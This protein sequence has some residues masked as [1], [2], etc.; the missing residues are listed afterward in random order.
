MKTPTCS[1][2]LNK[3]IEKQLQP[4]ET[5]NAVTSRT[6]DKVCSSFKR[7]MPSLKEIIKVRC[8][9]ESPSMCMLPSLNKV[10]CSIVSIDYYTITWLLCAFSLVVDRDLLKDTQRW[11]Q[12]HISRLVFLFSCPP[13]S[14]YK[15][16]EFLL[17]KTNTSQFSLCV[18]CNRSHRTSQRVN[19]CSL[20]A[21]TSFVIYYIT[22]T[23]KN[24]IYL[25]NRHQ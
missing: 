4:S 12:I 8:C 9:K 24:V 14:F 13:K 21:M 22:Y 19:I 16:F 15:P 10:C 5:F 18:Y 17:Y 25:L 3:F 7:S 20:H 2:T 6:V 23:Q 1:I 11:R